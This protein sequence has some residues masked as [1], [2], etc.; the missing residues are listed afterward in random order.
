M[1]ELI[2]YQSIV[3]LNGE[4]HASLKLDTRA[5]YGFASHA[6]AVPLVAAEFAEAHKEYAIVFVNTPD[7]GKAAV[8]LLSAQAGDGHN[9]FVSAEGQW[10]A[11]YIPA[12]VRRYPFVSARG[13]AQASV[14]CIDE[15]SDKWGADQGEP[16]FAPGEQTSVL[17]KNV[18]NLLQSYDRDALV[19]Q[20]FCERLVALDLLE[21]SAI[22]LTRPGQGEHRFEGFS[23]VKED[24][25]K[26][27]P[28]EVVQELFA[29]GSLGVIYA[30]LMS[31][32][33][34]GRLLS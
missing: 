4:K 17:L 32:S 7:G 33:N 27:L 18:L 1:A 19:T 6:N 31:L 11:N 16:L 20:A 8:A 10:R 21:D 24:R 2:F 14:V 30:H 15:A 23:V 12:F 34:L 5:H 9:H 13:E 3:P 28:A 26:A 25:L 29:N 22:T